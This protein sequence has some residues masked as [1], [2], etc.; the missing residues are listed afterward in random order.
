VKAFIADRQKR[1]Q[2]RTFG[3]VFDSF[4]AL[5][6]NRSHDYL[7][8]IEHTRANVRHLLDRSIIDIQPG[9][10]ESALAQYAP[11]TRDARIRRLRSVFNEAVR[12]GWVSSNPADKLN[13]IGARHDEVRIYAV[14]EVA[15]MLSTALE[16]D[17]PLIPFLAIAAF[18]GLRPENELFNLR[19]QDVHIDDPNPQIVIRPETSKTRRRR[20]VDISANCIE[21]VRASTVNTQGRVVPFSASTLTRKRQAL[22]E[23]LALD[24]IPDGFR[25]TYCSAHLAKHG[26]V[27]KL[28]IQT[29]HSNP[30]M[31]WRHYYRV[32]PSGDADKYWQIF[33]PAQAEN[34]V[35]M[36]QAS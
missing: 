1:M 4:E 3:Q 23:D 33:P 36:A 7:K 32:M 11:S 27:N 10:L 26:D 9:D 14:E 19:W 12:Q 2:S 17:K 5:R 16:Q 22:C 15:R 6:P 21:W 30:G 31:L 8:E 25:H 13:I 18:C 35:P 20:F 24:W 29:G 28:L 34:V